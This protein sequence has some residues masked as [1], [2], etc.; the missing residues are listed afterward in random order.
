MQ[1]VSIMDLKNLFGV[2][3]T[4]LFNFDSPH[5]LTNQTSNFEMF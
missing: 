1:V 4:S 5:N 2:I 3:W